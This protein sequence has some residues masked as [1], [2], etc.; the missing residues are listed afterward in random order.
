MSNQAMS[1]NQSMSNQSRVDHRSMSN[2]HGVGD[3]TDQRS[4]MGHS[5]RVGNS[6]GHRSSSNNR[7][8]AINNTSA[9]IGLR[10]AEGSTR[11]LISYSI[12]VGVGG[13]LSKVG[14]SVANSMVSHSH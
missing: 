7:V 2:S 10:L 9:I 4:S 14:S 12:V 5:Y 8:G 1:A 13:D 3:S 11:V 6:V